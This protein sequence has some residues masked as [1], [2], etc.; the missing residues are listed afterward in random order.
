V[1]VFVALTASGAV[2][3]VDHAGAGDHLTIQEGID[4]A[5]TGDTLLV[6][7]G[8]YSGPGNRDIDFTG[9]NLV[10]LSSIGRD[11]T[12][13]DCGG[14]PGEPHRGFFF[15]SGEDTTSLVGGF[16]VTN[17]VADSGAAIF[18]RGG[19]SPRIHD[20]AL[21]SNAAEV[22]GGLCSVSSFPIVRYSL[23]DANDADAGS[24][25]YGGGAVYGESSGLT[26]LNTDFT[27]NHAE[28]DLGYGGAVHVRA[29]VLQMTG[30]TL[31]DNYADYGGGLFSAYSTVEVS[32]CS[33]VGNST[34]GAGGVWCDSVTYGTFEDCTF[35]GNDGFFGG[36][37]MHCSGW[38]NVSVTGCTFT[39]NESN[40]AGAGLRADG[41][42]PIVTDCTF[43]GNVVF[44]GSGGGVTCRATAQPQFVGC[45]FDS[46]SAFGAAG[47]GLESVN[48]IPVLEDCTFTRNYA[49]IF[50]G[51]LFCASSPAELT[52]CSFAE[53]LTEG[54]GGGVYLTDLADASVVSCSF[55]RNTAHTGAGLYCVSATP[56][57][58]G[59]L[60]VGNVVDTLPGSYGGAIVCKGADVEVTS[61]TFAENGAPS[62]GAFYCEDSSPEIVNTII[63]FGIEGEAVACVGSSVPVVSCTDIFGNAG[64]DWAGCIADQAPFSGNLSVD[65]LF[66]DAHGGD[67]RLLPDSPC[68]DAS[69]C[70]LIG[71]FGA[72]YAEEPFITGI[73]DVGNDEGGYIRVSWYRSSHDAAGD[74]L[75]TTSYALYR[76][77]DGAR[78]GRAPIGEWDFLESIPAAGEPEYNFVAETLC[79]STAS[80]G[81]CWS[82]FAVRARTSQPVVYFDSQPDSGYSYDNV[83][84]ARPAN[85]FVGG[86]EG[87]T[88]VLNWDPNEEGDLERYAVYRDTV[89]DFELGEP[90]AFVTTESFGDDPPFAD[91]WYRVTAWDIGGNESEPS[92]AGSISTGVAGLPT[93]FAL[94]P[95]VPNPFRGRTTL[96]FELP[97]R[98]RVSVRVFD[99]A[100]R[101]VRVVLDEEVRTAGRHAIAWDGR[102]DRGR[103][104]ASGI[105]FFR[106]E[107]EGVA[108][109]RKVLL[110][111]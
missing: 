104:V 26:F 80:G 78:G 6:A 17:A 43:Y 73:R 81:I 83:A 97:T 18:V 25:R 57:L 95:A 13:I 84:P 47:G 37:G 38:S 98:A 93:R 14:T 91:C 79:D 24:R 5:S 61:S 68:V 42:S 34:N 64:G 69:G 4:A 20:C 8:V 75:Y 110:L 63:A 72:A 74:S 23:F 88:L 44:S 52:D 106:A 10:L 40:G 59:C 100:G 21:L 11:S 15:H 70:G 66:V 36:G 92:D 103:R 35:T 85:L 109:T 77:P 16:T 53:N 111:R 56:V 31:T 27:G 32:G 96:A 7:P 28:I 19:A 1:L 55:E 46:N 101:L 99:V 33:F 3:H 86:G 90:L 102:D 65:P 50:G 12:F 45:V 108:L 107:S 41:A 29:C 30:C 54:S 2:V 58:D 22:G 94:G 87:G 9:K 82:V 71:A 39:A 67:F 48:S 89:P 105:Y 62:G 60:F 49:T 51:G 76:R